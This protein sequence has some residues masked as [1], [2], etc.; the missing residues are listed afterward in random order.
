M[1][2]GFPVMTCSQ[3]IVLSECV[4][5]T[6]ATSV[7]NLEPRSANPTN[8]LQ[9]HVTNI[10]RCSLGMQYRYK[11]HLKHTPKFEPNFLSRILCNS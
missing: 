10:T 5:L 1:E 6:H 4:G 3:Q 8:S 7:K 11:M 2:T 9:F